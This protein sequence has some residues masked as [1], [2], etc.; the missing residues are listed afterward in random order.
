[1]TEA[2]KNILIKDAAIICISIAVAVL[3]GRSNAIESL[4]VISEGFHWLEGFIAGMFFTSAF[5][6][7]PAMVVLG[8]IA[9]NGSPLDT[10]FFGALGALCGDMVLFQF[11]RESLSQDFFTL[12][13]KK[14]KGR[15]R[16]I[17]HLRLFR[18]FTPFVGALIVASPLPDELA[19][20]LMGFSKTNTRAVILFAARAL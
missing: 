10:A 15:L 16:H 5:S 2:Q 4:L 3:L 8:K 12:V 7:A 13:G 9:Q 11:A 6:T 14:E 17:F 18:W 20:M 19:M 1:M